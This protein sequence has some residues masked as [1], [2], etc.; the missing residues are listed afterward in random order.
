MARTSSYLVTSHT[1]CPSAVVTRVTGRSVRSQE[2][3]GGGSNNKRG[4]GKGCS[5]VA[6][7]PVVL[8]LLRAFAAPLKPD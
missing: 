7:R 3:S 8:R 2:Y 5:G 6:G 1:G 4:H